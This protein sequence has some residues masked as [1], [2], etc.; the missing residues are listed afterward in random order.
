[1]SQ[2]DERLSAAAR[3]A[4][5]TILA[6]YFASAVPD[7]QFSPEFE[8]KMELLIYQTRVKPHYTVLQKVASVILAIAL[9]GS[10]WLA[11]DTDAR[12]AVLGWIKEQYENIFQYHF[13]GDTAITSEQNYELGWL[14]EGYTFHHRNERAGRVDVYY[15]NE[16]GSILSLS[17]TTDLSNTSLDI[18][19]I[20]DSSI[21]T[22]VEIGNI[23]ADLYLTSNA[24]SS[25]II[26]WEDAGAKVL[27]IISATEDSDTLVK[28][29]ENVHL[30]KE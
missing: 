13:E 14:P 15:A 17:Y 27:F 23:I 26:A 12:A 19:L 4:G 24:D 5:D 22:T 30:T 3:V 6:S 7:H 28:L 10:L 25:N 2:S 1:M 18:F 21:S 20:D 9:G 29:A 8:Q 11:I 16:S